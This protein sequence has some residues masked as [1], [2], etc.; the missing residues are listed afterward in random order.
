MGRVTTRV[1]P[2]SLGDLFVAPPRATLAWAHAERLELTP[3]R[4]GAARGRHLVALPSGCAPPPA[5]T[6]ASLVLDDGW[7]WFALRAVVLRGTLASCP[8][9]SPGSG[10]WRELVP[11]KV[12]AWDYGNLHVE[13]GS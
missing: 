2:E 3:V 1:D 8:E 5:G 7:S 13:P 11:E 4:Y 12:T 6:R 9:P 10:T